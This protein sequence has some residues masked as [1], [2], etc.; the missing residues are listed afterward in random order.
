MTKRTRRNG[1]AEQ[2][3]E[4]IRKAETNK[5]SKGEETNETKRTGEE[6]TERQGKERTRTKTKRQG[7][8]RK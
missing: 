4:R 7:N 3:E 1:K 6:G 2:G 8:K 5:L